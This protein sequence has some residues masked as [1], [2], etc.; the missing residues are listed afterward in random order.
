MKKREDK[1]VFLSYLHVIRLGSSHVSVLEGRENNFHK[2][3]LNWTFFLFTL[4]IHT[5]IWQN[6]TIPT[7]SCR[8][9]PG[10]AIPD[11]A[12]IYI[13]S[14][15]VG[16]PAK[17]N[18]SGALNIE[19]L[20]H[21][22]HEVVRADLQQHIDTRGQAP[23][24]RVNNCSYKGIRKWR[25]LANECRVSA[26]PPALPCVCGSCHATQ[27]DQVLFLYRR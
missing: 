10:A 27:P 12:S 20:L 6:S 9:E 18:P 16:T 25:Q 8:L 5:Y 17:N 15:W 19:S 4:V 14:K 22:R 26:P 11:S 1:I 24:K 21:L 7:A 13:P 3:S 2:H 23:K